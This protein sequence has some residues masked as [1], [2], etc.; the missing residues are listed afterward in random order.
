M[1]IDLVGTIILLAL[2]VI[3]AAMVWLA[4]AYY[5]SNRDKIGH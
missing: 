5:N 2:C 3:A 4:G 1:P